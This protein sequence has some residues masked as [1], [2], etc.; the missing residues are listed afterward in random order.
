MSEELKK[1]SVE[2]LRQAKTAQEV[3]YVTERANI[4]C[5]FE[6]STCNIPIC[7]FRMKLQWV[8]FE[9]AKAEIQKLKTENLKL[10]LQIIEATKLL[11]PENVPRYV[12]GQNVTVATTEWLGRLREVLQK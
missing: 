7:D 3:M 12:G 5:S 2:C 1:H 11:Q 10:N 8:P 6:C 9:D 4:N